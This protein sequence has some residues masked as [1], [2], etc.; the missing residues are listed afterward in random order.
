MSNTFKGKVRLVY[1]VVQVSEKF[2]KREFIV[3]EEYNGKWGEVKNPVKFVLVQEKCGLI[4][5]FK[6]G[7]V[8]E[9]S[10]DLDGREWT[11]PN[12]SEPKFFND[13]KAWK[14][15][16]V[17]QAAGAPIPQP[18]AAAPT[19]ESPPKDQQTTPNPTAEEVAA[20]ANDQKGKDGL[21]F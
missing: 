4:D 6:V 8:V 5:Q 10:F 1:P 18:A 19:I 14:L 2:Q 20:A 17:A 11:P 3:Q 15:E 21:P 12:E 16:P 9:V 7:D 13:L